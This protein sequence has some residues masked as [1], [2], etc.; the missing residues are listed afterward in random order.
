[1]RC[2]ATFALGLVLLSLGASPARAAGKVTLESLLRQM[3]DL[4]LL[5]EFPD[6]PYVTK[7][8]SSY[9]RAS[10]RPG[11]DK[12]FANHDHGFLLYDGTL[13]DRTGYY[14]SAPLPGASPEGFFAAGTNVGLARNVMPN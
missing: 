2:I 5:A 6:P 1:M 3:T 7:Q 8:F 14:K 13:A 9:D 4:S 11:E 12:W 10:E